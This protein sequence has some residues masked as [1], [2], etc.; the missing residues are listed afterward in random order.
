M[1]AAS[2]RNASVKTL[3]NTPPLWDEVNSEWM[4]RCTIGDPRICQPSAC[5]AELPGRTRAEKLT[6]KQ[7]GLPNGG[8]ALPGMA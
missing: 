2:G 7:A 6:T 4:R 5:K 3:N 1:L 8:R